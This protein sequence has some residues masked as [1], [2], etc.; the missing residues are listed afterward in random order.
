MPGPMPGPI[1]S[2]CFTIWS[3]WPSIVSHMSTLL[4]QRAFSG[5]ALIVAR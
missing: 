3:M 4:C 1:D 5:G 2:M